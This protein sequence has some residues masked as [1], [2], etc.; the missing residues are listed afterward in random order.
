MS[1]SFSGRPKHT[2][3]PEI[4][5]FFV[6]EE[7]LIFHCGVVACTHTHTHT[8]SPADC[9]LAR[10]FRTSSLPLTVPDTQDPS[11][12][13]VSTSC[14]HPRATRDRTESEEGTTF[15]GAGRPK[16]CWTGGDLL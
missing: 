7:Q 5:T 10:P 11:V 12:C 4:G 9:R 2:Q 6:G 13:L 16:V 3:R 8:P 15:F 14:R 1:K